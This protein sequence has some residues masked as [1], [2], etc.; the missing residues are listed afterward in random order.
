MTSRRRVAFF[1]PSL[2]GG[3][4]ERVMLELAGGLAAEGVAADLV[5]AQKEGAYLGQVPAAVR[6]VDLGARRVLTALPALIRYLRHERPHAMLSALP[7]ANVIAVWARSAAAVGTRLVLS[8]HTTASHS[9]ANAA[10]ARAR[11]LP[12]FMRG[13][14]RRADAVVA[15]SDGAADDLAA[16]IGLPRSRITRIYNPVVTPRL[17]EK[18]AADLAHPWFSDNAPPVILGVGRLT[19]SKD[20]E[21]LIEAFVEVRRERPARLV[22][23][24]EGEQRKLLESRI[25]VLGVGADAELPG[26]VD[27]P[28][29]YMRRAAVFVLASRWEGFGNALV[30]AMACGTAVV[31]TDCPGGPREIL[32]SGRHGLLTPVGDPRSMAGAILAQ[33]RSPMRATIVERGRCFSSEAAL[34]AYR[35]VLAL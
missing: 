34:A 20:F 14:Y 10:Q 17:F 19:A 29:Q 9:A 3:G 5:V 30:E 6:I 7:H 4:A 22:I 8:E 16:L 27:N 1:V 2:R 35:Q 32:E 31:S 21:T 11:I 25:A 12:M 18:A 26:F 15:V 24:G 23:L 13:A 28:F 33:L